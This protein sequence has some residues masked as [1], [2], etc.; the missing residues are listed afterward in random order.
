MGDL[1][2][3]KDLQ[4]QIAEIIMLRTKRNSG[5]AWFQTDKPEVGIL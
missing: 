3:L 4:M 5:D 2:I 1:K